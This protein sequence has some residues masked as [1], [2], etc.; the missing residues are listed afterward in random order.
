M[1]SPTAE[2]LLCPCCGQVFRARTMGTSYYISG[3]DT[4]LRETGSIEEVRRYGVVTCGECG[5]SADAWSFPEL[6]LT[7]SERENLHQVL[8]YTPGRTTL[9]GSAG[10]FERFQLA[11]RCHQARGLDSAALAELNLQAYYVAR[12]LGRRD[13]VPQLRDEAAG[14][15]AKALE[16]ELEPPLRMRYAYLAGELNRRAGRTREALHYFDEALQAGREA[17]EDPEVDGDAWLVGALTR[18][19]Q[20]LALYKQAPAAE[21]LEHIQD[22]HP[23]AQGEL[24]RIL[25]SRRDRASVEATLQAWKDAPG[26]DRTVMLRELLF[27]PPKQA[28]DLLVEALAGPAP[29]DVRLAA[30]GLGALGDPRAADALLEALRRG[31]LSTEG[32]VVEALRN[33]R[34]TTPEQV[35]AVREILEAWEAAY[36]HL[37]PDDAWT[38]RP[39]ATPLKNYLYVEGGHQGLELLIRDMRELK[40]N[41]LWDKVPAGGPV[42]AALALGGEDVVIALR[43]LL[44]AERPAARRWAAYCLAELKVEDARAD[45]RRLLGDE[46]SVV[47][48]QAAS[49]LARLKDSRNEGVVLEE[50]RKLDEGDV[51]FALHFLVPFK[52]PEVKAYLL[53]LRDSG[54]VT[55]G[56]VLPLLGRQ[57]L[58]DE[59]ADLLNTSL[60]D[61]DDDTRAGAVTGVAFGGDMWVARRLRLLY[62]QEPSDDVRRRIVFGLGRL[63]QQGIERESTVEFLRDRL[64]HGNQRLRFST[65]LTLLQ[66]GDPTGVD[67]VRDRAALF[68][69]SF[70]RYD[71]V[72]PALK[73]LAAWD[74]RE[75][76]TAGVA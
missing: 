62:D 45:V 25:A 3:T 2:N 24:R 23:D 69:E 11:A 17:A 71:L 12:D 38:F 54:V 16:E 32:T 34:E 33:L 39:D 46:D 49:A 1:A 57:E 67:I 35:E 41:D 75:R 28:Y 10:D 64:A 20:A 55:P 60:L 31:I 56:E 36:G 44:R 4:D 40:E 51:P 52:S 14:L 65:A 30:R 42:S 21:L 66:L 48:L 59:L 8:G 29:E 22:A 47:R 6:E 74:A 27:D 58:D 61:T 76:P 7:Q 72:A 70:D 43:G 68:D 53:E 18:R 37:D 13:L 15:F 5:F 73:V 9:H 63:A 19:M 26:R 50:L